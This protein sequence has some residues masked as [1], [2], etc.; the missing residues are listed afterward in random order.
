MQRQLVGYGP[1]SLQIFWPNHAKI[2]VNFVLN[3]EEGAELTPL[4]GDKVSEEYGGEFPFAKK[5]EGMR[6]L[7]M[8][9][10][11]EYGSRTGLWRLI[12][13]FDA[14]NIPLTFFITGFALT[15][16]SELALYLKSSPHE[17]AGHGWRW[18]DYA[19]IPKEE[20]KNHILQCR[21][22]IEHL[23]GNAVSGWYTGRRSENTRDLL[24][25]IG[26]FMYDSDSYADD[27]P[28]FEGNHL[29]IPYTLD[30]N[31][32][33][34]GT[35]PGFSHGEAFFMHLKNTFDYL[36]AEQRTAMMTVALHARMSG[37]PGRC[38]AVKQFITYL[39]QFPD[40]WITRRIDIANYWLN[41]FAE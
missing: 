1:H 8:E 19:L 30:C 23:T 40:V 13:L 41:L 2:A 29:I 10:L 33:R 7:S 20:E 6:N 15:L 32:F 36:Y 5:Q 31:D 25:E 24:L 27:L 11:F 28:Y 18:I 38:M 14:E 34:F 17:L 26:G 21:N 12:R 37:H 4:N 35:S 16:N 9:S 39:K 22:T 3:Y